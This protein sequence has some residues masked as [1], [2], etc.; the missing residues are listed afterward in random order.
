MGAKH[1]KFHPRYSIRSESLRKQAYR[2]V[3]GKC[4]A[5]DCIVVQSSTAQGSTLNVTFS[6]LEVYVGVSGRPFATDRWKR[7]DSLL[8]PGALEVGR[9]PS[10]WSSFA[11]KPASTYSL[12]IGPT[13]GFAAG[14]S[15][16][17]P[18]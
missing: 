6:D 1:N 4:F 7:T 13:Q 8:N 17:A 14:A 11:F 18:S 9:R 16:A 5:G 10:P 2:T 12:H 15:K 3:T